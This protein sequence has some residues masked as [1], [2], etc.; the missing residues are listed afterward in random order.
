M[1]FIR[2][3]WNNRVTPQDF[4]KD[5]QQHP[6]DFIMS[7]VIGLLDLCG[8]QYEPNPLFLQY[9]IHLFFA[10]PQLCMNTFLDLTKVNSF[11]LV[12]LI[13]NCGDTLFNNLEIGTDFSARCA[14]NA[15]KICLQHPISDVA[16]SAISKLS[17]SPTFSVLIAS[18]RLY[19]SSEVIS[20][21]AHFNQV[22]PQSDLPPSIPFPM[23]LLRRAM[24]ESNLSSSILFT[25][26]DIATAVISNIDIWTFVPC[27]K[28][29]I[30]PDT[31]YH[32]YLHVVSGF[33]ANP[34]LQL[35]YMTTNLL[36]RVLKHMNDSEIQNEDKSNT[37][38]SR[39]DVSALFSD[40]RTNSNTKH[41]M[42]HHEIENCDFLGQSDDLAQIEK[43]FTD[44]PS[45]VDEDH[46]IDIVYQYP[47]L[48]S[49]LVEHIMKNM[50]AKRPEYAVSYSKQ[51]LP[52][53]SDF[54]WLL[55]QQGNF[56]EFINHSLTLATTITE[57]NQ[58]ESIWLLPLTLLRFTWGTTSNSMRAKITEFI[59]SQP[60]GVNFFLRH[61]LQYQID[62]NPIE[63]LGDK[64]NDK[65]TPF[66]ESVTVLKELLN[67]EINVSDLDLSH[68]PYLVPSVLVWANEKAPDNYDCLT[69]IPNQNSHLINF[70]FFSA[71]LS[72]VKPVRRWMCA[73]EEP[74][75]INMLLFKPDN[76]IEINSLIVDQL[77]AFCRV[78]PMTTEQLIRIVASWRA[79]VEIFGIEKFTKTLLNQLVWKTMHSLVPEDADNLYKSV[80]YVLAI[81]LSENTD[82]VDNVLQVISEIVVNEIETMTSA[83]GL[84]DFALIIIC[85]RKEKWETSFD[86]L[87]KY[88][89]TMLEE[90]PT[91]QNTKTS[92][93][94][95]VLKTS[96]YTPRLQEKVTDEA[97]EILY[98]IRD[99]QT[100]IDFFIVKQSVQEEAAQMSS[101]ESRFF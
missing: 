79:W 29:F 85:T 86:W 46:I 57:P 44:F 75:M 60:S 38:Y 50:T 9:L 16:I 66:N 51:I 90:D 40:L 47:A 68:K 6:K 56:I 4:L 77:G 58:F 30:P 23:T 62:T 35:A 73:A 11:G 41:E 96:L 5:V 91:L 18:A 59:D 48:S 43:L 97:F 70:L 93:A 17:E 33:I 15:L 10:A 69:S 71:M 24:L 53:H 49:S 1:E 99:W 26:H 45:T 32:L 81:L 64:L 94:L 87:L 36:V 34:T 55:L 67:N 72:I 76:I 101:S 25:V 82:Y 22:V 14:F 2:E 98:K 12:R 54:E 65:S 8:K 92:F 78:T 3:S 95:S 83:I 89:F 28:S 42:N 88:C 52:I 63:S 80:A 21:R 19:F 74:D 20:L 100:M 39:T 27:S 84:A 31:F 13:I 7:V 37:R 61:L